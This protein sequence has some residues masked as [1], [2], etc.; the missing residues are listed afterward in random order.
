MFEDK[1]FKNFFFYRYATDVIFTIAFGVNP[2]SLDNPKSE[3]RYYGKKIFEISP[4]KTALAFFGPSIMDFF[5]IPLIDRDSSKFFIKVFTETFDY[6]IKNNVRR[7]DFLDYLLQLVN[8]GRLEEDDGE[9]SKIEG[10]FIIYFSKCE[11][12]KM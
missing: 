6:R 9:K 1:I 12:E 3:F 4:V 10:K 2:N 8:Y 11:G 5:K 7:K